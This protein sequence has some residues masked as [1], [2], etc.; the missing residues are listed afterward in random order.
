MKPV[1]AG[2][3]VLY[4]KQDGNCE[5]VLIFRNGVWDLPKGKKEE[6][7]S[8]EECACREVAE[9]VGIPTPSIE[10]FLLKTYHEYQR[11]GERHGKTTHWYSMKATKD[12][13]LTPE[14]A[15]G[16]TSAEWVPLEEAQ[17]RVGY[18]N[19]KKVLSVFKESI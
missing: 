10:L 19:L 5:V 1:T 14:K 7:E 13:T 3:G 11:D 15:E 4:R 16:I 6:G 12:E 8:I 9:E 17:K 18:K 2:G